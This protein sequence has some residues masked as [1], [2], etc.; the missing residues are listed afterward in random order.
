MGI[1]KEQFIEKT[2]GFRVGESE[3]EMF[4]RFAE[5]E[6]LETRLRSGKKWSEEDH[7][8]LCKLKGIDLY[9]YDLE[10]HPNA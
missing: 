6:T 7:E 2:G 4:T 8:R 5:I 3:D 10:D 9:A 1:N